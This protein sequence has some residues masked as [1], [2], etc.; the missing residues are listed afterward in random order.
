MKSIYENMPLLECKECPYRISTL[1]N[2]SWQERKVRYIQPAS[3]ERTCERD[4][5]LIDDSRKN[6]L[7]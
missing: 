4:C 5:C 2:E 3:N 7:S 6:K 1:E